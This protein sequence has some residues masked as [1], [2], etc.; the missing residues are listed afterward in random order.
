MQEDQKQS[1]NFLD[2][3]DEKL[4]QYVKKTAKYLSTKSIKGYEAVTVMSAL[5]LLVSQVEEANAAEFSIE[6]SDV[7][8]EVH[9][10]PTNWRV[11]VQKLP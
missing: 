2:W 7:T 4:G 8:S 11:T 6:M 10:N 5:F 3:N 9:P 1:D